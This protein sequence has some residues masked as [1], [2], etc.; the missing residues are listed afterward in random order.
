MRVYMIYTGRQRIALARAVFGLPKLILL[1]EP[2]SSLDAEAE[3]TV[4][5]AVKA[6]KE[7]GATVLVIGHRPAL[8]NL[9]DKLL[10]MQNGALAAFGPTN[11]IMAKLVRPAVQKTGT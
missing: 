6:L 3:R 5:A 10:V 7:H 9:T 8:M 11:E 1:D 4:A 2:T